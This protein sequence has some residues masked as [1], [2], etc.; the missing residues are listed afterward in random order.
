[1]NKDSWIGFDLDGTLAK[2]EDREGNPNGPYDHTFIGRPIPLMVN[3]LKE[4]LNK[5]I[6]CKIFTARTAIR[7]NNVEADYEEYYMALPI[8]KAWCKEHIG[9]ELPITSCKDY[10]MLYFYDDRCVQVERN[11]GEI[12]GK[13]LEVKEEVLV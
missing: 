11:T 4:Y 7:M 10:D 5:G 6:K 12:I 3:K 8:I 2:H 9:Q 13:D 1:M